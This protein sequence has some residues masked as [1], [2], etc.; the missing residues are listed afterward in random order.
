MKE[1]FILHGAMTGTL[2]KAD[3]TVITHR[4]D[5]MILN[6]GFDFVCEALCKSA[7]PSAMEY[8]AVGSGTAAVAEGDTKLGTEVAR[9]KAQ[10]THSNGTKTLALS[11]TFPA[12]EAT[13]ALTEAGI[14]NAASSGVFF[15]RVVF[16]VIN[17]GAGDTYTITFEITLASA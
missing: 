12:G 10:Y 14:C 6:A 1:N 5:N 4:K 13:G 11:V 15:D 9:K 17:K 7:R 2:R 8:I 16:P 3:G